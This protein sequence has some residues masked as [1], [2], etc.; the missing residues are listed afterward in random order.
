MDRRLV[1]LEPHTQDA[2]RNLIGAWPALEPL[3]LRLGVRASLLTAGAAGAPLTEHSRARLVAA[4]S[5][6]R[7]PGTKRAS[8]RAVVIPLRLVRDASNHPEPIGPEHQ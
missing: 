3:A 4:L 6:Y 8:D 7:A 5:H 2:L 1:P